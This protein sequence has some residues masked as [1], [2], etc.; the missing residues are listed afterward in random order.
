MEKVEIISIEKRGQE[1]TEEY[2]E[3]DCLIRTRI[4]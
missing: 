3:M 1:I 4:Y 2:I